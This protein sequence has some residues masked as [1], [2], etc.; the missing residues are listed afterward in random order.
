MVAAQGGAQRLTIRDVAEQAG[1]SKAAASYALNGQPGVSAATR[2]RILD[3]ADRLGW[4]PHAAARALG[5]STTTSIGLVIARSP[6]Q[7]AVEPF[8]MEV[9]AGIE[10]ALTAGPYSLLLK[11]VDGPQAELDVYRTWAAQRQVAGAILMDLAV[12]DPRPAWLQYLG[13]EHVLF[14]GDGEVARLTGA[15]AICQDDAGTMRGILDHL[16]GLGH[17]SIAHVTG[18]L[19]LLHSARRDVAFRRG[20]AER[21]AAGVSLTGDFTLESGMAA[22]R[23]TRAEPSPPT[24]LIFDSDVMAVGG[25]AAARELGVGV[26]H[27]V[28]MVAWSGSPIC[29][30]VHPA[31]TALERD[32]TGMAA[33]VT[34]TLLARVAG[35]PRPVV[36]VQPPQRLIVRGSTAQARG[37][38]TSP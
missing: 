11:T 27:E 10:R 28:S 20:V 1:V 24:A 7:L 23:A 29:E 22:F 32:V 26:P 13:I 31:L 18:P 30:Y 14:G 25:L 3:T 17:R 16:I 5:S 6:E 35:D 4:Q 38:E 15:S 34:A 2:Q 21:G 19:E 33:Q 12:N 9:V 36:T 37:R 8:F